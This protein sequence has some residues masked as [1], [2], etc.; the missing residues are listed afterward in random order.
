VQGALYHC[1]GTFLS[2]SRD[3]Y[4]YL[5]THGEMNYDGLHWRELDRTNDIIHVRSDVD[6]SEMWIMRNPD[7]PLVKRMKGNK[8]GIDWWMSQT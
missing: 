1:Q 5:L 2:I 3:A 7:L 4:K 6:N 8:L